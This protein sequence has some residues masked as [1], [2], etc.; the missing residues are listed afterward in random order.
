M[1]IVPADD[2]RPPGS[3]HMAPN[4]YYWL[5]RAELQKRFT[6]SG[7]PDCAHHLLDNDHYRDHH[8]VRVR[9]RSHTD[10]RK[11]YAE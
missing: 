3:A 6:F 5:Y 11:S 10:S 8:S 7:T 4:A 9:A 2:D 1:Q